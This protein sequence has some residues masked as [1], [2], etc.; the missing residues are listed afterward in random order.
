MKELFLTRARHNLAKSAFSYSI[1]D[2]GASH[3]K[4]NTDLA[5][6]W[7]TT[8]QS[9]LSELADGLWTAQERTLSLPSN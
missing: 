3:V 1:T 2:S 5:K 4:I 7:V 8:D 9:L 6:T